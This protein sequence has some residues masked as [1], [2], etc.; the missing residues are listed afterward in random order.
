MGQRGGALA[1]TGGVPVRKPRT[2]N[3]IGMRIP[4]SLQLRA[5]EVIE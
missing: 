5:Q 2:A 1:P 3:A 4:L